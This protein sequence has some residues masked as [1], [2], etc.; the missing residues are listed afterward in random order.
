MA[1][2]KP[3]EYQGSRSDEELLTA[4]ASPEPEVVETA[5]REL[6]EWY[7]RTDSSFL[8][9]VRLGK[10]VQKKKKAWAAAIPHLAAVTM[11]EL[12]YW[13]QWDLL[14]PLAPLIEA[15]GRDAT[16]A[17]G[18]GNIGT[19]RDAAAAELARWFAE[20]PGDALGG[21]AEMWG[22]IQ[23]I[24]GLLEMEACPYA[25]NFA[26][27]ATKV[28]GG[29]AHGIGEAL[30]LD[31]AEFLE[32]LSVGTVANGEFTWRAV[33]SPAI[34]QLRALANI[35]PLLEQLVASIQKT[36][37][38][39]SDLIPRGYFLRDFEEAMQSSIV[40]LYLYG[41]QISLLQL[42]TASRANIEARLDPVKF[43]AYAAMTKILLTSVAS[44]QVELLRFRDTLSRTSTTRACCSTM[45]IRPRCSVAI[46]TS[47][48]RGT[49][50]GMRTRRSAS[51]L[52]RE[53]SRSRLL[54]TR[55]S[56]SST[57][58]WSRSSS[59]SICGSG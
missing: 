6:A 59:A 5:M 35:V 21:G 12:A 20:H 23:T 2:A 48:R 33:P 14:A 51:E 28:L 56:R 38:P 49:R 34:Q 30:T 53:P 37:F 54:A 40:W 26:I 9:Y 58:R 4:M 25:A 46:P 17:R 27:N 41:C 7:R 13:W 18:L 15:Y 47:S 43:P 44:D 36:L 32:D 42:L 45:A 55:G 1:A 29:R 31:S 8:R 11:P 22:Q 50:S 16:I 57:S 39:I 3:R 52:R 10:L 19:V 24:A